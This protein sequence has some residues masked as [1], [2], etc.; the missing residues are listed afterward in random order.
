MP[1]MNRKVIINE[2]QYKLFEE[3]QDEVT[4][5]KFYTEVLK[6]LKDLLADPSSAQPSEVLQAHGINRKELLDG[7]LERNIITR[8]NKVT[9]KPNPKTGKEEASTLA[10]YSVLRK[11]FERKLHRLHIE[12]CECVKPSVKKLSLE[13]V[14]EDTTLEEEGSVGGMSCGFAMQGGGQ[15]PSA[16]QYDVP[17]GDVQHRDFWFAGNK[18]N[19]K[20]SKK[21]KSDE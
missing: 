14:D 7:L 1:A 20:K 5:Y 11:N 19:K 4:Y 6:F 10:K 8:S 3:Y 12:L 15:N 18:L 13:E 21:K 16:G 17:L 2:S 9:E